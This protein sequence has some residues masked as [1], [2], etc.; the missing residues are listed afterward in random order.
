MLKI[1]EL[2]NCKAN[3]FSC[4][5]LG[6]LVLIVLRGEGTVSFLDEVS[7]FRGG[8]VLFVFDA[9]EVKILDGGIE[10]GYALSFSQTMLD[11]FLLRYPLFGKARVFKGDLLSLV[12]PAGQVPLLQRDCQSLVLELAL[13][14]NLERSR[15]LFALLML[16]VLECEPNLLIGKQLRS[17]MEE[18]NELLALN[19]RQERSTKFY[20]R[21]M[22]VSPRR[23]NGLCRSWF[24][25][26]PFFAVLMDWLL[27]EAEFRLLYS[28]EP[29]K[30]IAMELGFKSPQNFRMYFVRFRGM[31]PLAFRNGK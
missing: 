17:D 29:I 2:V 4:E 15:L 21:R 26:K 31:S 5:K 9:S 12:V 1:E 3:K 10:S 18:F 16:N 30:V 6:P 20:A 13:G 24:L 11:W 23:L 22:G 19:F 7:N 28:D 8:S 27:G 25:G 14:S